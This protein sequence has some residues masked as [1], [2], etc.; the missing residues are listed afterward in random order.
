MN[1]LFTLIV[2]VFVSQVGTQSLL[3]GEP[4]W[5]TLFYAG[6]LMA[7]AEFIVSEKRAAPRREKGVE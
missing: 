3:N 5:A 4:Y 6:A 1:K 2:V 7:T